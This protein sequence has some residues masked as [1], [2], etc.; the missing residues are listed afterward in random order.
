MFSS[1]EE[2]PWTVDMTRI[3]K[4]GPSYHRRCASMSTSEKVGPGGNWRETNIDELF[5]LFELICSTLLPASKSF[6]QTCCIMLP[7][8]RLYQALRTLRQGK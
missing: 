4:P 3:T 8:Q 6:P 2:T 7:L 5:E 1:V